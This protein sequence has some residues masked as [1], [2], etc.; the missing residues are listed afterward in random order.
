M[1]AV[2]ALLVLSAWLAGCTEEPA[3]PLADVDPVVPLY[4]Q[5][6]IA[7]HGPHVDENPDVLIATGDCLAGR[8]L[9][10]EFNATRFIGS[11]ESHALFRTHT[12]LPN[13]TSFI[14]A[15]VVS[16]E[17]G[18]M[19]TVLDRGGTRTVQLNDDFGLNQD[20]WSA[21]LPTQF[22]VPL[23][24]GIGRLIIACQGDGPINYALGDEV[25]I[26]RPHYLTP[27]DVGGFDL[28]AADGTSTISLTINVP[29]TGMQMFPT[30]WRHT[31]G[32]QVSYSEQSPVT[33]AR[34]GVSQIQWRSGPGWTTV[35]CRHT[36]WN[37]IGRWS[38]DA[39]LHDTPRQAEGLMAETIATL[40][41]SQQFVGGFIDFTHIEEGPESGS[42]T[43]RLEHDLSQQASWNTHCEGMHFGSSMDA[44]F[45]TP[46]ATLWDPPR[47]FLS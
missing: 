27:T 11:G 12:P 14:V 1:R 32:V 16:S 21:D 37:E 3:D 43:F 9:A 5:A 18:L 46:G 44:L 28:F 13:A 40:G 31:G 41:L 4:G 42:F 29:P 19:P 15:A 45:G 34:I 47:G 30:L 6:G 39:T 7:L 8:T 2:V 24:D 36:G 33:G 35:Q 20:T 25:R 23:E 22:H 17:A 10:Y 26:D 38:Y